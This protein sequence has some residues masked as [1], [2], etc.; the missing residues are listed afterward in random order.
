MADDPVPTP[1][2]VKP[3]WKTTEFWFSAITAIAGLIMSS[4]IVSDG[5]QTAQIIGGVLA[6]LT[7]LG[8]TAARSQVKK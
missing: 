6:V 4:G 8:Y 7:T 3:G 5:S 2:P 1:V